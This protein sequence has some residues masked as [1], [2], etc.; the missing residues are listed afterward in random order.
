MGRVL[1]PSG[2]DAKTKSDMK[3]VLGVLRGV[4]T[5]LKYAGLVLVIFDIIGY[6]ITKIEGYAVSKDPALKKDINQLR[7]E[8]GEELLP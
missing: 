6:A 1:R 3:K 2:V 8:S 5:F 7:Q 4:R